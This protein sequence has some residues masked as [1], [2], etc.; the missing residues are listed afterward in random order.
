MRKLKLGNKKKST[1]CG[2]CSG[3]GEYFNTDPFLF[4]LVFLILFMIP[5]VPSLVI[6]F[7]IALII[8]RSETI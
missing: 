3:L 4:R 7:L 2:V 8:N 6:Y 5:C 1:I